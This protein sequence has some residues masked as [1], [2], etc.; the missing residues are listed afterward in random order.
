MSAVLA[1][2]SRADDLRRKLVEQALAPDILLGMPHLT[3]FGLSET[4]LMKELAHRHWLLLGQSLGLHDADFRSP[5][6]GEVYAAICATALRHAALGR[7]RANDVLT[8]AT[9]LVPASATHMASLHRLSIHGQAIA[10][11]ELVST[12]VHRVLAGRNSSVARVR[13][14]IEDTAIPHP[15]ALAATARSLR[16][17]ELSALAGF[18]LAP[19]RPL[20]EFAFQPTQSQDFNGAGLFYFANFMAASDRALAS[21]SNEA[22]ISVGMRETYFLGNI[23]PGEPILVQLLGQSSDGR[24]L[25]TAIV[26]QG[27]GDIISRQILHLREPSA[28]R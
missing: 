9:S 2:P 15:R 19:A 13:M 28:I 24:H 23:E 18:E 8:I 6:G 7:A 25:H 21:W 1:L 3:P 17:G 22:P 11:V 16:R 10:E 14:P 20:R 5:G 26:R 4:W 27:T 12:F